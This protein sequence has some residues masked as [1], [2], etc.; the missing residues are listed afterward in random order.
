MHEF[1][2][3]LRAFRI[4]AIPSGGMARCIPADTMSG[5]VSHQ[6]IGMLIIVKRILHE[7]LLKH[8]GKKPGNHGDLRTGIG[9]IVLRPLNGSIVRSR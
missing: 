6:I 8:T 9:E 7:P 1:Q 2:A 3:D 5:I 4:W